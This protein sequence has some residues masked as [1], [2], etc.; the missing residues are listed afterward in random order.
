[1]K[2]WLLLLVGLTGWGSIGPFDKD[3]LC[4]DLYRT[5][6]GNGQSF[7]GAKVVRGAIGDNPHKMT[8]VR[9]IT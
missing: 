2:Y 9:V 1:M 6:V 7:N 8:V 3:S 4:D 5:L